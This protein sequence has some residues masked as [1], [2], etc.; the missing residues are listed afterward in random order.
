MVTTPT[1]KRLALRW[2]GQPSRVSGAVKLAAEGLTC[3][4]VRCSLPL[5]RR[6]QRP[7]R[8]SAKGTVEGGA[9]I[10]GGQEVA[11]ELE[12]VVDLALAG[13]ESLGMAR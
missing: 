3:T 11:T 8:A 12:E 13:E 5:R 7:N 4:N 1:G 10:V 9:V 6:G 2:S